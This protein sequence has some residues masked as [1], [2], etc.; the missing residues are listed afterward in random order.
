[1]AE[2]QP[3]GLAARDPAYIRRILP[4]ARVFSRLYFRPRAFG[5]EHMP[6]G[7]VL[8]VGNHSGG[9]STPDTIVVAELYWRH[10]GVDRPAYALVHPA[11]FETPHMG[12]HIRR[13]G[14]LPATSRM[15]EAVLRAGASLFVY[16]G[17][18]HDAYRPWSERH[19]VRLGEENA[20]LRLA[21]RH[22]IPIVPV[23]CN[24][25]HETFVCLDDGED[26]ARALGL[27]KQGVERLP[28]TWSVP[29]GLSLG[30]HYA[31][32]LPT[33]IDVAFGRPIHFGG[34]ARGGRGDR[35]QIDGL[36]RGV[37]A[38]MQRMLDDLVALRE[39]DAAPTIRL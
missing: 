34:L 1:V 26:L 25:G 7:Q 9:L 13:V 33:R 39:A 38:I 4:L 10:F 2:T 14:G 30:V 6:P 22:G 12:N 28:L 31:L 16:P 27:D 23:V 35:A 17:A 11:A 37:E 18:G 29:W 24:G 15:A 21:L 20:Y 5:L 8:L 32:P 3:E 19:R 36:H